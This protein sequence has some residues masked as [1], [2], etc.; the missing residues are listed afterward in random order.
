MRISDLSCFLP[1]I[2]KAYRR[3]AKFGS[4]RWIQTLFTCSFY[5]Q[6]ACYL[7][8][9]K[10]HAMHNEN[11]SKACKYILDKRWLVDWNT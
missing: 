2:K 1:V 11:Q 3:F 4:C 6:F 10:A 9:Q 7:V 5:P 8:K